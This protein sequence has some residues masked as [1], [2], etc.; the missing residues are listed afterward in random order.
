MAQ[1]DVRLQALNLPKD[2]KILDGILN[3]TSIS[4]SFWGHRFVEVK[5]YGGSASLSTLAEKVLQGTTEQA[6]FVKR[7][8]EKGDA[9]FGFV[10]KIFLAITSFFSTLFTCSCCSSSPSLR[11]KIET[12]AAKVTQIEE[13]LPPLSTVLDSTFPGNKGLQGK[14]VSMRGGFIVPEGEGRSPNIN[15]LAQQFH[16]LGGTLKAYAVFDLLGGVC[17]LQD[18]LTGASFDGQLTFTSPL[19][20]PAC[21][22][23]QNRS[24]LLRHKLHNAGL[25]DQPAYGAL[26]GNAPFFIPGEDFV[27]GSIT[28]IKAWEMI[29]IYG[30][31]NSQLP[32]E[33]LY[34]NVYRQA[35]FISRPGP[36]SLFS[37]TWDPTTMQTEDKQT[38]Q[39]Q[40]SE[41]REH[42]M[43][44]YYEKIV[45]EG[46][47]IYCFDKSFQVILLGLLE[48]AER[49]RSNLSKVTLLP[50]LCE[51]PLQQDP[52]RVDE[53]NSCVDQLLDRIT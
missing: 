7:L 35:R 2:Q 11:Q 48:A 23:G 13:T 39:Y 1:L 41:S 3:E 37:N 8:Y 12:L 44:A 43:Q 28:R 5:G 38:L 17:S 34:E 18:A 25:Q 20:Y 52:V 14:N 21:H 30:T 45:R 51:D 32:S 53:F 15:Q 47:V 24:Q 31:H 9:Q 6:S 22:Q 19:H 4:T 29:D 46:G 50:I 26:G 16:H 40:W 42:L 10:T 49:T 36:L 33:P 27:S